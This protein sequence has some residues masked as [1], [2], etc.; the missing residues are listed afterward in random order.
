MAAG[1]VPLGDDDV[2]ARVRVP[3]GVLGAAREGRDEDAV[4]VG[5]FDDVGGRRA[6]GVRQEPDRVV[7]GDVELVPGDLFHPAGDP[8]ARG[9]ALVE[10]GY[11]V[12]GEGLADER[13]VAG[14]DHLLDV[15]LADAVDG[16][17]GGHDHVEAVGLAVGVR[18]HPVEVAP[19]V[20]GRGVPDGAEH[21][22]PAR[23]GDGGGDRGEGGEAEDGVLDSQ[24]LAQLRLH[25]R[26]DAAARRAREEVF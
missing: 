10:L 25:G 3:A 11:V 23:A 8:P 1:L 7:E 13:A 5:A 19:E 4:V 6:E 9:L 2:D 21:P 17:L 24:I 22:E 12:L 15:G 18:L 26:Q 14:R 20:V 16:L